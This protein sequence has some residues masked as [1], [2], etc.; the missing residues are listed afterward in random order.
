MGMN[1]K[2]LPKGTWSKSI[3]YFYS[4]KNRTRFWCESLLERDAMLRLEFDA[5]VEAYKA[6]PMS[7]TYRTMNGRTARYTPDLLVKM[8]SDKVFVFREVKIGKRVDDALLEKMQWIRLHIK[9]V[10]G[11]NLEIV[12]DSEIRAGSSIDNFNILYPYKRICIDHADIQEIERNLPAEFSLLD[13]KDIS[14]RLGHRDSMP[15]SLLA[16]GAFKF[17]ESILLDDQTIIQRP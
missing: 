12:T 13:L 17:D 1:A 14:R 4:I 11:S 16:H 10:Y 15:F 6:Q 3:R 8:K 5:E 2:Q 7:F 9:N